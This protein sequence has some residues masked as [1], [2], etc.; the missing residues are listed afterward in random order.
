[1]A[2]QVESHAVLSDLPVRYE[3]VAFVEEHQKKVGRVKFLE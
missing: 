1:M 2:L 3:L